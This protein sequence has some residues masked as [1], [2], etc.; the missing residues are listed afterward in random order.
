MASP[1]WQN[2]FSKNF[3]D[4]RFC[5][6]GMTVLLPTSTRTEPVGVSGDPISLNFPAALTC[7]IQTAHYLTTHL[8]NTHNMSKQTA[9]AK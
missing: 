8:M 4:T 7:P 2:F 6:V 3:F 1:L 5:A 9:A